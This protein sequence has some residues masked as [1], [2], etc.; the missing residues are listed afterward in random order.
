MPFGVASAEEPGRHKNCE[1]TDVDDGYDERAER[2]KRSDR[3]PVP[4]PGDGR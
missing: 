3:E 1:A 4:C 2:V